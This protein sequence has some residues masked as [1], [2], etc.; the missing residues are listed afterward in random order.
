MS[1]NNLVI[2]VQHFEKAWWSY[3][4]HFKSLFTSLDIKDET[5]TLLRSSGTN[6]P[7]TWCIS[8]KYGD[9]N[10]TTAKPKN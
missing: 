6:H 4:Q 7:V 9:L 8:H 5:S 1:L 2:G 10:F 3:L